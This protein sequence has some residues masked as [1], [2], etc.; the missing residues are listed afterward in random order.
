M[1]DSLSLTKRTHLFIK[2]GKLFFRLDKQSK[3]TD[4]KDFSTVNPVPLSEL[5]RLKA[6]IDGQIEMLQSQHPANNLKGD[7]HG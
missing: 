1:S 4:K 3:F 6:W 7:N 5:H 2:D